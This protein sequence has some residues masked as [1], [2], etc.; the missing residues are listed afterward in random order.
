MSNGIAKIIIA[1]IIGFFVLR[2]CNNCTGSSSSRSSSTTQK[3]QKT[4]VDKLITSLNS[5]QNYSIILLDMDSRSSKYYHQYN[6]IVEKADTVVSKT[7][8][9]EEVPD[10][11]FDANVDNMGMEIVTRKDGVL[12]KTASPA[13]YNH[14]VGNPKYGQWE[15]R[16][17][18]SFW[19]FYGKYAFMS[20]MFNMMTYPARRSYYNDYYGGGYY[21]SRPYYGPS[22]R[23]VY[24]TNTYTSSGAGKS[25]TWGNKPSSFKQS[26]RSDVKRSATR[27]S[28]RSYSS[29]S[30]YSK[31]SR[32]SSRYSSSSSRSR[33]GGFGK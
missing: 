14:Y 26:V 32:S 20:S 33:S 2:S 15:E 30:S 12:S 4:P 24:G 9:W 7:T 23:N 13:G 29:S 25:S 1:V 10:V 19:S 27:S 8:D 17:G 21:G 16:N 18:S 31:K 11:F 3:W 22:G 5:E 28:S 6:I